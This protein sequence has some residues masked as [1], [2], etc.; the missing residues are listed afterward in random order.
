MKF[1]QRLRIWLL[2]L[3]A[4]LLLPPG[5]ALALFGTQGGTRW[6][7]TEL[8]AWLPAEA[9]RISIT[10]RSGTLLGTLNIA[11]FEVVTQGVYV[12]GEAL[13]LRWSPLA[14]QTRLVE[15]DEV[16][17][18][19]LDVLL[20]S[21]SA[22]STQAG[23]AD[24]FA[25]P[26]DIH[27]AGLTIDVFQ[28]IDG[29]RRTR[30]VGAH[31][32]GRINRRLAFEAGLGWDTLELPLPELKTDQWGKGDVALSGD[33][34][35]VSI[36]SL[37]WEA[38]LLELRATANAAW[39][40]A[41]G[42]LEVNDLA[43][44]SG[45]NH[46]H[47]RGVLGPGVDLNY[48]FDAPNI[49]ALLPG[50][51]GAVVGKG[52]VGGT[53]EAP[54]VMGSLQLRDGVFNGHRIARLDL[55]AD[56]SAS[57][58]D[59]WLTVEDA[60]VAEQPISTAELK[61]SGTPQA[62]ELRLI[63]VSDDREVRM[64][65]RGGYQSAYWQGAV[66][67]AE[68]NIPQIGRWTLNGTS[69]VTVSAD[70]VRASRLCLSR[71]PTVVCIDGG[72]DAAAGLDATA[73]IKDVALDAL[74]PWLPANSQVS[75]RAEAEVQLSGTPND[76]VARWHLRVPD[77]S[78]G[79]RQDEETVTAE[80]RDAR[81]DGE[82]QD[83]AAAINMGL[84]LGVGGRIA[85][86]LRIGTAAVDGERTLD[87]N[88][89]A[90][91]TRLD[92]LAGLISEL[93]SVQGRL[94]MAID[95]R[96]MLS[97]PR[98]QGWATLAD[99]RV[100]VA[101]T[102]AEVSDIE[103]RVQGDDSGRFKLD[104][105]LAAGAGEATI[106]GHLDLLN[107]LKPGLDLKLKGRD[108]L[109]VDIPDA[110]LVLS[111]DIRLVGRSGAPTGYQIS[112][113]LE[114]PQGHLTLRELPES[115]VSLSDDEVIAGEINGDSRAP[116]LT[117]DVTLTLG[118]SVTFSGFGL[119]TGFKGSLRGVVDGQGLRID[120][121]IA[122]RDATYQ[123]YGQDLRVER[124]RLIFRGVPDNPGV[125]LV[126]YRL[127]RDEQVKAYIA[128][129]GFLSA[130]L[131]R[132]YSEPALRETEVLAYLLTGR[133]MDSASRSEGT[134]I[135]SAA[136]A[137][138]MARSDPYLQRLGDKFGFDELSLEAGDG[139]LESSSLVVGRYLNP[140]LYLGYSQGLFSPE[141][142]VLLRL[143]LSDHLELESRSGAEQSADVFYRLERE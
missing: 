136:L 44:T 104:G 3:L 116:M 95:V 79:W 34:E 141:G 18:G 43:L 83:D 75:G 67:T 10:H 113:E 12:E 4:I 88:I 93:E 105:S 107:P 130:P 31:A 140:D 96:G 92:F 61:V 8:P 72:W 32:A 78:L 110:S 123:A 76:P 49:S 1:M 143:R 77:G 33:I 9:P 74:A 28:V 11:R 117:A 126:A 50:A 112:G 111:P 115:A 119:Q 35:G 99:G 87:G 84:D 73:T 64:A 52:T 97:T 91:V 59:I 120:G 133:G 24:V 122:L 142:T 135:T 39:R 62:H 70:A 36:D 81:I 106:F 37:V 40:F 19:K 46:L 68:L 118:E 60:L 27:L 22:T 109:L 137:L 98:L 86:D 21:A 16:S 114:V 23:G 128:I 108:L 58:G 124:G 85:G 7:L 103:V 82:Y 38:P 20:N 42:R 14:L 17:I 5:I 69:P 2:W 57:G 101:A 66:D 63:A 48:Q 121:D 125:D 15:L 55:D 29:A 80:F 138:G 30:A 56:W 53:F 100:R 13:R 132:V 45:E 127:S 47:M 71:H 131:L 129:D 134:D 54:L 102:G 139:D 65:A 51:E 6:L 25:L 90:A 41:D 94:D 26:V 89:R